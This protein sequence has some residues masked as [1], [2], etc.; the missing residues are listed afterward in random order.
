MYAQ[1]TRRHAKR[2]VFLSLL[3]LLALVNRATAQDCDGNGV[4]D[5]ID[6]S[7]ALYIAE[8]NN[9]DIYRVPLT[10]GAPELVYDGNSFNSLYSGLAIDKVNGKMY[11]VN[12]SSDW[13]YS[14]NIDGTGFN[15]NFLAATGEV[16]N[17]ISMRVP[18]QFLY[19]QGNCVFNR[20]VNGEPGI[21]GGCGLQFPLYLDTV[22]EN[23]YLIY[24]ITSEKIQL[25][26][27]NGGPG[28]QIQT[29]VNNV[30]IPGGM[31]YHN[32]Q[33]FWSD[34][35]AGTVMRADISCDA[36]GCTPD[37]NVTTLYTN[38]GLWDVLGI[39]VDHQDNKV[40][41]FVDTIR[42]IHRCNVDGSQLEGWAALPVGQRAN[43]LAILPASENCNDNTLIDECDPDCDGDRIPDDCEID[44]GAADCNANGIPDE[45][46]A[47]AIYSDL[48]QVN[49]Q[50]TID[51]TSVIAVDIDGNGIVDAVSASAF[52]NK[53]AWYTGPVG[54]SS[55][56]PQTVINSVGDNPTDLEAADIDGDGDPDLVAYFTT[57]AAIYWFGNT[58]GEAG[59]DADGF[60]SGHLVA[61]GTTDVRDVTVADLD[62][63]GD[64]D[65][66]ATDGFASR[67]YWY[68]NTDGLGTFSALRLIEAGHKGAN[69][70]AADLDGDGDRDVIVGGF[71]NA[72]IVWHENIDG[73]GNFGSRQIISNLGVTSSLSAADVDGD[74]DL[75]LVSSNCLGG[76]LNWYRNDGTG[77]FG[78]FPQTIATGVNC[79]GVVAMAD[80]DNDGDLDAVAAADSTYRIYYNTDGLG[81]FSGPTIIANSNSTLKD[82]IDFADFNGD[83][84]ID[85]LVEATNV[86]WI[87]SLGSDCDSNGTPDDCD[88]DG[89]LFDCNGNNVIDT[90]DIGTG[91]AADCDR[92][93][94]P[95]DCDLSGGAS[96]CNADGILD[97]CQLFSNDCNGNGV[98]DD[99]DVAALDC[100]GNGIPD[101]CDTDCNGD[102]TPDDCQLAGNDCNNNGVIDDCDLLPTL[103]Q[104][105]LAISLTGAANIQSP[106][107][108]TFTPATSVLNGVQIGLAD[109][110]FDFPNDFITVSVFR[111][112]TMIGSATQEVFRP[113]TG[114][115][116]F[117]FDTPIVTTPGEQLSLIVESDFA[118][119]VFFWEYSGT[120]TYPGGE[121]IFAGNPSGDW[122]FATI[123]LRPFSQDCDN[124]GTLDDCEPT[125]VDCNWNGTYDICELVGNDCNANGI[126][127]DCDVAVTDCNGDGIPDDCQLAANDCNGDGVPDECNLAQG[128]DCN[129]NGTVDECEFEPQIDQSHLDESG[130]GGNFQ[131]GNNAGQTFTPTFEL[132]EAIEVGLLDNT[133]P[134]NG[135]FV[136]LRLLRGVDVLATVGQTVIAPAPPLTRFTFDEPIVVTPG[137]LLE[138]QLNDTGF[139]RFFWKQGPVGSS[140][141]GGQGTFF[142]GGYIH[143]RVFQTLGREVGWVDCNQ[144]NV[145]DD[146]E[147]LVND[148]NNNGL[149]DDCE[150]LEDCNM[151]GIPDECQ[152]AENDCNGDGVLDECE[153]V[154]GQFQFG[155]AP[156][157]GIPDNVPVGIQSVI[158]VP[159]TGAISDVDVN[160][161]I[162]HSW[163]G[164]VIATL[165]HNGTTVTVVRNSGGSTVGCTTS[166][167]GYQS[168]NFGSAANPL[169]LDD[170]APV[171]IDCYDGSADTI[172]IDDFAGPAMPHEPLAAFNGMDVS[173]D[174][175]LTVSDPL[176]QETGTLVSWS[177]DV[178]TSGADC[179]ANGRPDACDIGSF[180]LY[181]MSDASDE[182]V[183]LDDDGVTSGPSIALPAS[184]YR[185]IA[186]DR[187]PRKVYYSSA[188][189]NQLFRANLDG[190]GTE[191]LVDAPSGRAITI[192]I[193][194]TADRIYWLSGFT[195]WRA[196]RD[197]AG[198]ETVISS[199]PDFVNITGLA[200]DTLNGRLY[201]TDQSGGQIWSA[202]LDGSDL[203]PIIDT[204]INAPVEIDVDPIGGRV[205]FTQGNG[206][207]RRANTDGANLETIYSGGSTCTGIVLDLNAGKVYFSDTGTD[208]LLR[209]NLDG[210]AL[211]VIADVADAFRFARVSVSLDC[212]ANSVPDEC[213]TG[214]LGCGPG[215]EC[216]VAT[217]VTEGTTFGTLEDNRGDTGNDDSCGGANNMIDEWLAFTPDVST[218]ATISTC[219]PGT[220]FDSVLAVF[221]ACPQDGGAQLACNDDTGGA[222]TECSL[223]GLNRKSTVRLDAVAGQTYL[224]RVSVFNDNFAVQGGFGTNYELSIDLCSKGDLN[225]D[226]V[227]DLLDVPLFVVALLDPET[228]TP[229]TAC[230]ADM[231][232]D[233]QVD[234]ADTQLFTNTLLVP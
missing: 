12:G 76:Q 226:D 97:A 22:T 101:D 110:S 11:V 47:T 165:S 6:K 169:V 135:E 38:N 29:V 139:I 208:Q 34:P 148:C 59:G 25:I 73:E 44:A 33:V 13:I 71:S 137:E 131:Q 80:V 192:E 201:L 140:Y 152:L 112:A 14:L 77:D 193:D 126:P 123:E 68:E 150:G 26:T 117:Y 147:V 103:D 96:D 52:D 189:T 72:P 153:I 199:D 197:G 55:F 74:G 228:A 206:F 146:C 4:P 149:I 51:P 159:A 28:N 198:V 180:L 45:C 158:S 19:T 24:G 170:S 162:M 95:D 220:E 9:A 64:A 122:K 90:C 136:T 160:L 88:L 83:G 21:P 20:S 171:S 121:R 183:V 130:G 46:E 105:N 225:A 128:G 49:D 194:A 176:V 35:S 98:P 119:L 215:E 60:D 18:G 78:T 151:D 196:M 145:P 75:D 181:A 164:D 184:S 229:E 1:P 163:Q 16:R 223:S 124:D 85:F 41:F 157:L 190:T 91:A 221:D 56:G 222:P 2:V 61:T 205:Y 172:A 3:I 108:Q 27:N 200:L 40:Y 174:W 204:G 109:G 50:P 144:N 32:N 127:D 216:D 210:S 79:P 227:I 30:A 134:G 185:G 195:V 202:N 87:E 104:D 155:V 36:N 207:V 86:Y 129:N 48:I 217:P 234:G 219:N 209:C 81:S 133:S 232:G 107:E 5:N 66:L 214:P 10:G 84:S 92:N 115:T 224:I 53:I 69:V 15:G 70:I 17:D 161:H 65:I 142:G 173:G 188:S 82:S 67:V 89:G 99:C 94:I 166:I 58:T 233:G 93:G 63:D 203:Q 120:D 218:L 231:N 132:L 212:N 62:G 167:F 114:L 23:S 191:V 54:N 111:D 102:G 211:E 39:A 138:V 186:V 156:N 178:E 187:G 141:D 7:G 177:I 8:S 118:L 175:V 113:I 179:N 168:N 106:R 143:D 43:A 57:N 42:V 182:I 100:N 154:G 125:F 230:G 31:V 213:E 37:L 116:T